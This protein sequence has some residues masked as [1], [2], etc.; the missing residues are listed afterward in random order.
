MDRDTMMTPVQHC[1]SCQGMDSGG[2]GTGVARV[3]HNSARCRTGEG[4]HAHRLGDT[5]K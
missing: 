2:C 3:E 1:P 4:V 5:S